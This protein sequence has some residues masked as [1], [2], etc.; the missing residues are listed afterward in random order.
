MRNFYQDEDSDEFDGYFDMEDEP[1]DVDEIIEFA[2]IDLLDKKLNQNLLN[3]TINLL[4][5]SFFWKFKSIDSKLEMVE[6][7]YQRLRKLVEHTGI[8]E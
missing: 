1:S 3:E 7:A 4:S 6:D 5:K 2:Q 8:E